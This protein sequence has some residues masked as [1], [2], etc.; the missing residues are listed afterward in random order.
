MRE[1]K[2]GGGSDGPMS[3]GLTRRRSYS[4]ELDL[5]TATFTQF[6]SLRID[7]LDC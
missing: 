1:P 7:N 3:G 5:L 4:E 6:R 2:A